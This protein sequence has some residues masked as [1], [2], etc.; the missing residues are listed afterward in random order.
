MKKIFFLS[1]ILFQLSCS[2][3]NMD[4]GEEIVKITEE[5][6]GRIGN[7]QGDLELIKELNQQ[8]QRDIDELL[9]ICD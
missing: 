6:S 5:Y 3:S 8:K 9:K 2:D 4:C 7:A 1:L